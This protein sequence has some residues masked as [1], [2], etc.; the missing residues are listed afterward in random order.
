VHTIA[1]LGNEAIDF[2]II[3]DVPAAHDATLALFNLVGTLGKIHVYLG[4]QPS[5]DI[6]ADAEFLCSCPYEHG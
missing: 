4:F 3:E 5:L 6:D 1:W 2:D